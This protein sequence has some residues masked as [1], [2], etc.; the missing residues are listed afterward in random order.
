[1]I[2]TFFILTAIFSCSKD[3]DL[4]AEYVGLDK[5]EVIGIGSFI[6]NDNYIISRD[7]SIVL[8]V[9]SNDA[10]ANLDKVK[11]V[12]TSQAKSGMIVINDDNTL[13]YT[14]SYSVTPTSAP[15]SP[16]ETPTTETP[17]T[18]TPTTE[19]PTTETPTT[20]TPTTE[21]PTT[22]TP[23]TETPTTETPTNEETTDEASNDEE[24][25]DTFTYTTET[26]NEDGSVTTEEGSVTITITEEP[27]PEVEQ[28]EEEDPSEIFNVQSAFYVTSNGNTSNDGKSEANPWTLTHAVS[29]AKAGDTVFVKAGSYNVPRLRFSNSGT[30]NNPIVFIGYTSKEGDIKTTKGGTMD[31]G[32]NISSIGF[33]VIN[34]QD[35][36]VMYIQGNYIEIHNIGFHDPSS[37]VTYGILVTGDYN[38]FDNIAFSKI[39]DSSTTY[40]GS[41][42]TIRG[43]HNTV[44]NCYGENAAYTAFLISGSGGAAS[45]NTIKDNDYYNDDSNRQTDYFFST[46]YKGSSSTVASNNLFQGNRGYRLHSGSHQGHGLANGGGSNNLWRN[47]LIHRSNLEIRYPSS[48]GTVYENNRMTGDASAQQISIENGAT[49]ITLKNNYFECGYVAL[50]FI[51]KTYNPLV[52]TNSPSNIKI[53]NNIFK[54]GERIMSF[55]EGS[56][57]TSPSKSIEIHH[58]VFD[59]QTGGIRYYNNGNE[60]DFDNNFIVNSTSSKWATVSSGSI[61]INGNNNLF[62]NNSFGTPTNGFSG[63]ITSN[64]LFSNSGS[65]AERYKLQATSPAIGAGVNYAQRTS[66]FDGKSISGS[67]DIGP[68]EY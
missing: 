13:T 38:V 18:E 15:E 57:E 62:Y 43:S 36:Q 32:D 68:F 9:L 42:F 22:E 21:T 1:M 17:T 45:F 58:N 35:D 29:M 53:Y 63:T 47:N 65:E 52:S 19:T 2:F 56:Q 25:S 27:E 37:N 50:F 12:E 67:P 51:V 28:E 48:S 20:E 49:N 46:S 10:F 11:I 8:D 59:G 61:A 7:K 4:L 39:N 40:M 60:V 14:P 6:M 3:S 16:V 30:E 33:P 23:T 26:E 24:V 41:G 54:G 34:P 66:D 64:P 5:E 31:Y 55:G 44:K